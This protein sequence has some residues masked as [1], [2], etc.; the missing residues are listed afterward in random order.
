MPYAGYI[1][2]NSDSLPHSGNWDFYDGAVGGIDGIS[3]V[4]TTVPN[5]NYSV[6]FWISEQD[7]VNAGVAALAQSVVSDFRPPTNLHLTP[8]TDSGFNH[9]DG[10]T[11][12]SEPILTGNASPRIGVNIYL[13]GTLYGTVNSDQNG[14]FTFPFPS[15]LPPG[16]T[17]ITSSSVVGNLTSSP[18]TPPF[19]VTYIPASLP[20]LTLLPSEETEGDNTSD[21][22]LHLE[23]VGTPNTNITIFDGGVIIGYATASTNGAYTFTTLAQSD[24]FHNYTAQEPMDEAGNIGVSRP[25]GVVIVAPENSC[26]AEL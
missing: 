1:A 26:A 16:Q 3:Q 13:N 15:S 14:T 25:L 9:T 23:G 12:V 11:N 2:N 19:I 22:I 10:I 24:G 17:T 7:P 6:S 18:S 5:T 4:L 20:T 21:D 8:A